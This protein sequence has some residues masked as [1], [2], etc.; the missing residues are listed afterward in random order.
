M[1]PYPTSKTQDTVL[2]ALGLS[3]ADFG[4]AEQIFE[5]LGLVVTSKRQG[6]QTVPVVQVLDRQGG[7]FNAHGEGVEFARYPTVDTSKI[8]QWIE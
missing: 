5:R 4:E 3:A 8:E 2:K 6:R 1:K 7:G